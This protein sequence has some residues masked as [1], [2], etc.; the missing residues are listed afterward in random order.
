MRR[1]AAIAAALALAG[2]AALHAQEPEP[3]GAFEPGRL[4]SPVLTVDTE[5]L[6][7]ESAWGRRLVAEIQAETEALNIENRRLEAE[8][9][10]E[11][12]SLTQRRPLM[13][14]EEFRAAAEAFDIRVQ[15][16]RVEQDAKQRDLQQRLG[17]EREGFLNAA[18][19][20]LAR[21]M[22]ESGAAVMMDRR[23]VILSAG[24]VDVTDAAIEAIDATI[25]DGTA[26]D[27][28]APPPE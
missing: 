16:I 14:V 23:S 24:A 9:T 10:D 2:A 6:F 28:D 8:L 17:Q 21:L 20:I 12:Q 18:T 4:Q 15:A 11:E 19:P 7:V 1:L 27:D 3:R 13:P 5:R 25:G 26:L 22:L